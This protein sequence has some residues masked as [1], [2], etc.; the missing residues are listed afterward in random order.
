VSETHK[1]FNCLDS[2]TGSDEPRPSGPDEK[3]GVKNNYFLI[4]NSIFT[5]SF[6][7][8][9]KIMPHMP[10]NYMQSKGNLG[11]NMLFSSRCSEILM[12]CL[13]KFF[14]LPLNLGKCARLPAIE[15][16]KLVWPNTPSPFWAV[17][18]TT[19]NTLLKVTTDKS[20]GYF[21]N[22]WKTSRR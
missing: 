17:S 15:L 13:L 19:R 11:K 3:K 14:S 12:S 8:N 6:T 5:I 4:E 18:S 1:Q 7:S 21:I 20:S 2:G 16:N 9:C 10:S 22:L